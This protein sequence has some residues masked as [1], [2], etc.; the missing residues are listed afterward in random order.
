MGAGATRE[1]RGVV[2]LGASDDVLAGDGVACAVD[3]GVFPSVAAQL[4]GPAATRSRLPG[5]LWVSSQAAKNGAPPAI[6]AI[7]RR[8][9]FIPELESREL[10][11][12]RQPRRS[13]RRRYPASFR[14]TNTPAWLAGPQWG[15]A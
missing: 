1:G 8:G 6:A 11:T 5:W 10:K 4:V 2:G 7:A 9:K 13:S 14:T 3:E 15:R 12:K